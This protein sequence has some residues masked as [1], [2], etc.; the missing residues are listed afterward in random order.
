MRSGMGK[1]TR[2]ACRVLGGIVLVMVEN[3][4]GQKLITPGYLFNCDPTC[5]ELNG[6]LYLFTTQDPFKVQA[7]RI[8][9]LL[10]GM[11]A[12]HALSTTDFDHETDHGSILTGRD[13]T[14]DEEKP[15]IET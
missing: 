2:G 5:R 15:T 7:E 11:F 1:L 12:F 6:K 8:N 4:H 3:L 13:V 14:W 9:K 10:K